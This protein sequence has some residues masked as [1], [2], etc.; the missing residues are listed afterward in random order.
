M[1]RRIP[2]HLKNRKRYAI[3][4]DGECEIWYFQMLKK[5]NPSLPIN[6]E[7]KLA[8]KTTLENQFKKL[9]KNFM[10]L[11]TKFFGLLTMM[12]FLIRQKNVKKG[13]NLEIRSSKNISMKL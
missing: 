9:N 12:L 3:I 2:N 11:M 1:N 8:V 7:P 5:H 10:I 6:I 4:G 13:I